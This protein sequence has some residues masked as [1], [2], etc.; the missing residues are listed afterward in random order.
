MFGTLVVCLPSPHQG[1]EVVVKHCG[2]KKTFKTSGDAWS[3]ACWYSDVSHEVLPVTS[4]HR[5]VLTFNLT[6]DLAEERPSAGLQRSE[7]RKLRHTLK[8]WLLEDQESRSWDHAYHTLDHEYTEAS[9]S[10][11]A[12]K[13]RDLAQVQ[14]LR[15]LAADLPFEVFL[16]VLEKKEMGSCKYNG[17]YRDRYRNYDDEDDE[18]EEDEAGHHPLDDIVETTYRVKSLVDL[19]GCQVLSDVDLDEDNILDKSRF[20]DAEAEEEYEGYMGNYV[21]RPSR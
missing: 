3:F 21:S 5:W 16:A 4:G 14:C 20:D 8:I 1:G 15:N 9:I 2:E 18:D 19:K 6:L 17:G 11:N 13:S 12:L 7:T 10:L